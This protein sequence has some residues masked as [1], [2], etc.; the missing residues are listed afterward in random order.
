MPQH[1]GLICG[2]LSFS[3]TCHASCM[4]P[5]MFALPTTPMSSCRSRKCSPSPPRW[6]SPLPLGVNSTKNP[7]LQDQYRSRGIQIALESVAVYE[8]QM[9]DLGFLYGL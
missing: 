1:M 5:A 3:A 8:T 7:H 4:D 6:P 9:V 2:T